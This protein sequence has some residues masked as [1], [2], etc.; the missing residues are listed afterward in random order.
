MKY[1]HLIWAALFRR[2]TRTMLTLLSVLAAFLLFGLLDAVRVAFNA[3]SDAAGVDRMV[4]SSKYSIIQGLPQSLIPR[5]QA[6]PGVKN[7]TWAN[8]FGGYYQDRKNQGINIAID[9]G[10]F[11]IYPEISVAP[12]QLAAFRQTR[13]G[14]IVGEML[15]KRFGWKVGDKVP[16]A[17]AIYPNK[18]TGE[19]TW[20]FDIVGIYKVE[21]EKLKGLEQQFFFRWDYFDEANSYGTHEVGWYIVQVTD[22]K[23]SDAVAKAID[24]IS[25]NSDHETKTQTEQAFNLSFAKQLGDIG[26]IVSA[27]MGA[28]FFTL[29]LLTG[30]T[31][32]QA[33]RER[34]PELATLKTIGFSDVSLLALVFAEAVLLIVIGGVLGMV[35]VSLLLPVIGDAT[36]GRMQLPPVGAATWGIG[37]GLMILIGLLV[38]VLPALRAMRLNIVDALAGR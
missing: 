10:Y 4:V 31:M 35:L 21:E 33:V 36:G 23:Q 34:I 22:P 1:F 15:A 20:T 16:I 17:G 2:K 24:A 6:T 25:A 13:T 5:I 12:D 14:A 29:L 7:L 38:G 30:N 11:D 8:W 9:P 32:A 27:I 19:T 26:L 3:G 28:V 18:A 37:L